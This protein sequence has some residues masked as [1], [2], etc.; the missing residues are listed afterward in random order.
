M[1]LI[2]QFQIVPLYKGQQLPDL[3][4]L[5]L[6]FYFLEIQKFLNVGVGEDAMASADTLQSEAEAL[7]QI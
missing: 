6:P 1:A 4:G 3:I 7:C 5:C 2:L